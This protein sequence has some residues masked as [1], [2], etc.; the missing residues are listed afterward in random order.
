MFSRSKGSAA[1]AKASMP[2]PMKQQAMLMAKEVE[3]VDRK[4]FLGAVEHCKADI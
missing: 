4:Q 3:P 1:P 2:E